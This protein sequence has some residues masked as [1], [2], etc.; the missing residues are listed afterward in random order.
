[1]NPTNRNRR[2]M[3][4]CCRRAGCRDHD[5]VGRSEEEAKAGRSSCPSVTRPTVDTLYPFF[6]VRK[7]ATRRCGRARGRKYHMVC[8]RSARQGIPWDITEERPATIFSRIAFRDVK[9]DEYA[10]LFVSGGRRR[11]I[12]ATTRIC[13]GSRAIFSERTSRRRVCHGIE[14]VS[15]AA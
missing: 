4:G 11:S 3:L 9:P 5:G 10:G 14:I 1:M 8:T 13:C 2:A 6:R 7:R 15:V 12:S